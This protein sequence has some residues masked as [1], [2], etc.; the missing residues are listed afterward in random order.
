MGVPRSY[1]ICDKCGS[2][3]ELQ[4]GESPDDFYDECDCGGKLRYSERFEEKTGDEYVREGF[5]KGK[6]YVGEKSLKF[7]I[8]TINSKRTWKTIHQN[9]INMMIKSS[10]YNE[11]TNNSNELQ[12]LKEDLNENSRLIQEHSL[13][14]EEMFSIDVRIKQK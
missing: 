7:K 11:N 4:E 5:S 8:E 3:Y 1:L 14:S 9:W 10:L 13:L 12:K 6:G 2:Y